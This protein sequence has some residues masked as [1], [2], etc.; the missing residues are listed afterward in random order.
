MKHL[1]C[2]FQKQNVNIDKKQHYNWV[3]ECFWV[4]TW[5]VINRKAETGIEKEKK[6]WETF[7]DPTKIK[8]DEEKEEVRNT[9]KWTFENEEI[10]NN[11]RGKRQSSRRWRKLIF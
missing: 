5:L 7:L 2:K 10:Y 6:Q 8:S 11:G 3:P 1:R 9:K 4:A